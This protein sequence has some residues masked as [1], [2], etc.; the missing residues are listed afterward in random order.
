MAQQPIIGVSSLDQPKAIDDYKANVMWTEP[1]FITVDLGDTFRLTVWI[2]ITQ[3]SYL[4]QVKLLF[5]PT[6]LNVT[7]IGYTAGS[8]SEWA[9][10]RTG[11]ATIPVPPVINNVEGYVLWGESCLGADYVPG[12]IFASLMWVEFKVIRVPRQLIVVNFSTIND[13][14]FIMDPDLNFIKIDK[15]RGTFIAWPWTGNLKAISIEPVQVLWNVDLV[16]GKAT[17]F[18]ITYESTFQVNVRTEV[19][20]ECQGL[21][22]TSYIFSYEFAPGRN[23]FVIG[24]AIKNSPFFYPNELEVSFKVIIDP[25]DRILETDEND[26]VACNHSRVIDTR[27]LKIF[28][29]GVHFTDEKRNETYGWPFSL[30]SEFECHVRES[31]KYIR[32]TFPIAESELYSTAACFNQVIDAGPRPKN[33]QEAKRVLQELL[34]KL[35]KLHGGYYD[36][37]VGVV[38]AGWFNTVPGFEGIHGYSSPNVPKAVIVELGYWKAAA[39]EIGHTF[40]LKDSEELCS[41]YYVEGRTYVINRKTIMSTNEPFN[42]SAPSFWIA[43]DEYERLLRELREREKRRALLVSGT[44]FIN[45][46]ISTPLD[47]WYSYPDVIPDFEN[48]MGNYSISFLNATGALLGTT[49]FNL[50]FMDNR[51]C[52]Y[53]EVTFAFTVP[54]PYGTKTIKILSAEGNVIVSRNVSDNV[55]IVWILTPNGGEILS[56]NRTRLSWHAYDPDR[57]QLAYLFMVSWDGGRIWNPLDVDWTQSDFNLTL[58][59]FCG[60]NNYV[61]RVIASDGVNVGEDYSDGNFT[62]ASFDINVI[63]SPQIIAPQG[64]AYYV[65]N[66]TSYGGFSDPITLNAISPTTSKLLFKWP[67]GSI[68]MP[69]PNGSVTIIVEVEAGVGIESGNYTIVFEGSSITNILATSTQISVSSRNLALTGLMTRKMVVGRGLPLL[70]NVTLENQ[71][72]SGEP[73]T[74]FLYAI[75][76]DNKTLITRH[77]AFLE[78]KN[79]TFLTFQWNTTSFAKG[80]YTLQA[81][82]R[83]LS[84]EFNITDNTL[85]GKWVIISIIGDITGPGGYPDGKVDMRDVG[86]A[87]AAFGSYPG[88][89]RWNIVADIND[90]LKVDMRDVGRVAREFGKADP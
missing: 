70:V 30:R 65:L 63:T 45:G 33:E 55:P 24:N 71:G 22:P 48:G 35:A 9:T 23:S 40:R 83:P 51:G 29:V 26:N 49:W 82:I 19:E 2:N 89:P 84:E 72:N 86:T 47:F 50:T 41:G 76:N 6:Y 80:N 68:I 17:D 54:Y 78:P 46:T 42:C 31:T 58:T 62:I 28:F 18:K 61:L 20:V 67:N 34:K 8:T 59:G 14:T 32:A 36:R 56:S 25:Y 60:G 44:C 52:Y 38:R 43:K 79:S 53:D 39:H 66:I 69:K 13:D 57:E 7:A 10:H 77:S 64:K 1:P 75:R 21:N 11:G 73:Y 87:A 88:R 37:V 3:N 81:Y 12:P 90:D 16:K 15:V 4:W 74:L 27:G 5:D 85:T